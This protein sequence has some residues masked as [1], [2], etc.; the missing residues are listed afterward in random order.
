MPVFVQGNPSTH[1]V[2]Q[3]VMQS[4]SFELNQFNQHLLLNNVDSFDFHVDIV[5]VI[6][7]QELPFT[8]VGGGQQQ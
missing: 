7:V 3:S 6:G 2:M 1:Y 5:I 8:V 4:T